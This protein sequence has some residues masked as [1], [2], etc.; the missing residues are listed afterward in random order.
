MSPT[1]GTPSPLHTPPSMSTQL[2]NRTLAILATDAALDK[3][4]LTRLATV[5]HDGLARAL[6]PSHTPFDG[7][8]VFAVSTGEKPLPDPGVS[9]FGLGHAAATAL[10]RAVARAVHAATPTPGDLQPCWRDMRRD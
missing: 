2:Q 3:A 6:V 7:D 5:A 1:R 10:A 9:T 4:A 8:L